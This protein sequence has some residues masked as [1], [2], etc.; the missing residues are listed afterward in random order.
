[1]AFWATVSLV[2]V[3][4]YGVGERLVLTPT[5]QP[6]YVRNSSFQG[7]LHDPQNL[8]SAD[9][10]YDPVSN[11][12]LQVESVLLV[13]E[14]IQVFDVVTSGFNNFIANGALLVKKA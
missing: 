2:I 14:H 9:K 12:W 1:M 8:T 13:S 10:I 6:I 3:V 4:D 5:E 11:T 7:W